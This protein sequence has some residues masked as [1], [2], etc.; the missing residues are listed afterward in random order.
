MISLNEF[1]SEYVGMG[2][3]IV[4]MYLLSLSVFQKVF[5]LKANCLLA[6]GQMGYIVNKFEPVWVRWGQ[7]EFPKWKVWTDSSDRGPWLWCLHVGMGTGAGVVPS[8]YIWTSSMWSLG[9]IHKN[10]FHSKANY[11]LTNKC[12]DYIVNKFDQVFWWVG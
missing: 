6:N 11:P 7:R 5:Q 12:M 4:V 9:R 10:V 2:V 1:V 3:S 8:E